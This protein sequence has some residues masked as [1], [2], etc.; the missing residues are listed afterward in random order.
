MSV[1]LLAIAAQNFVRACDS[2]ETRSNPL[3][4]EVAVS[5]VPHPRYGSTPHCSG[6]VASSSELLD[7]HWSARGKIAFRRSAIRATDDNTFR[8]YSKRLWYVDE[9][10]QCCDCGGLYIFFAV[11]QQYWYETL[12]FYAGSQSRR[13]PPCRAAIRSGIRD[14]TARRQYYSSI[15][16]R[17]DL[18][19]K[20]LVE[21]ASCAID[22]LR[23]GELA[24]SQKLNE[25]VHRL[26]KR[27]V[28]Q[29]VTRSLASTL[30]EMSGECGRALRRRVSQRSRG[31]S[32][33]HLWSGPEVV[34]AGSAACADYVLRPHPVYGPAPHRTGEQLPEIVR[35][36][37]RYDAIVFPQSAT[38]VGVQ[39]RPARFWRSSWYVDE[40][41]QCSQCETLYIFFAAEQRYWYEE[42]GISVD[43]KPFD[44]YPCRFIRHEVNERVERWAKLAAGPDLTK[45][46]LRNCARQAIEMIS[47]GEMPRSE[48]L[49]SF[50]GRVRKHLKG[51]PIRDRLVEE[52]TRM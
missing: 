10:H 28:D 13:C 33:P 50:V 23:R 12:Q 47:A 3:A 35:V 8:G 21:L 43:E 11:E 16:S 51:E 22:M 31:G 18:D 30:A 9:L 24:P 44:C 39:S 34:P 48:A 7:R 20:Q 4:D 46:E 41:R 25:L 5:V 49:S 29:E 42:L 45:D 15:V 36:G 37:A 1:E 26:T 52:W 17:P 6:Q 32:Q 14:S 2:V 19:E 38:P 27:Q 40:L